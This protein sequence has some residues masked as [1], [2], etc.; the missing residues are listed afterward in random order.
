MR[1]GCGCL[2]WILAALVGIALLGT[3]AAVLQDDEPGRDSTAE[4][5]EHLQATATLEAQRISPAITTAAPTVVPPAPVL[6]APTPTPAVKLPAPPMGARWS[7]MPDAIVVGVPDM[8]LIL[9]LTTGCLS[10]AAHA[11]YRALDY[12]LNVLQP[13]RTER[14]EPL[15]VD[16]YWVMTCVNDPP[17]PDQCDI[18]T[19]LYV[20]AY[21]ALSIQMNEDL[22]YEDNKWIFCQGRSW[23]HGVI[24]D[25][26]ENKG[27][28]LR[29]CDSL[30]PERGGVTCGQY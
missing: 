27:C 30:F 10:D 12:A 16:W 26:L 2:L 8:C 5:K 24:W 17:H 18:V 6:P 11:T 23:I 22:V 4:E 1:G 19:G 13:T 3:L 20:S 25:T 21:D 14:G 28:F 9:G 7:D 15:P 29:D